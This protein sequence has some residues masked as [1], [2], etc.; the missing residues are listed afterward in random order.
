MDQMVIN[1]N[2]LVMKEYCLNK[3]NYIYIVRSY[4]FA[5]I[6]IQVMCVCIYIYIYIY[7]I[8]IYQYQKKKF[9]LS[10]GK[11]TNFKILT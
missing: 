1:T 2:Y 6:N 8:E 5:F 3:L 10:K 9:P 11:H 4:C 7:I